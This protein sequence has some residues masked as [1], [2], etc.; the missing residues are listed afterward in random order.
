MPQPPKYGLR[1]R[2]LRREATHKTNRTPTENSGRFDRVEYLDKRIESASF[3]SNIQ[4]DTRQARFGY[5]GLAMHVGARASS[6]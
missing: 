1:E 4:G 5:L 3:I 2:F 6:S